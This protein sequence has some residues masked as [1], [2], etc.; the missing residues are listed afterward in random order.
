MAL[1]SWGPELLLSCC[2]GRCYLHYGRPYAVSPLY[3]RVPLLPVQPA[4]LQDCLVESENAK[5][6]DA[7]PAGTEG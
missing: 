5:L 1:Y 2:P 4:S 6:M 7:K 3:P